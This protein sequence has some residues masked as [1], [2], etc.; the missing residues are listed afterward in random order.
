MLPASAE[1]DSTVGDCLDELVIALARR[2][3][4]AAASRRDDAAPLSRQPR[5]WPPHQ[6]LILRP[7]HSAHAS[8]DRSSR[9]AGIG[10]RRGRSRALSR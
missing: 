10:L 4:H 9:L 1:L 5:T 2:I 8:P 6:N 7:E 3:L